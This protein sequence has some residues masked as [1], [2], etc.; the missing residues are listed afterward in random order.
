MDI[1]EFTC[2]TKSGDKI[3]KCLPVEF[4]NNS[5]MTVRPMNKDIYQRSWV[6]EFNLMCS[7]EN[8]QRNIELLLYS[9]FSIGGLI[10]VPLSDTYG[11]KKTF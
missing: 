9:G 8:Y 11:Y 6:G 1:P 5:D 3:E 2:S 7:D 4:C 10:L